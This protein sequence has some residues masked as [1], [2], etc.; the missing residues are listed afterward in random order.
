MRRLI[1]LSGAFVA[2]VLC[3]EI[4]AAALSTQF[5]LHRLIELGIPIPAT[6]RLAMTA[7]DIVGMLPLYGFTIGIAFAIALP[8]AGW[9]GRRAPAWRQTLYA[10]AG[11]IGIVTAILVLQAAFDIMPIAGARSLPGLIAQ[12]LAGAVAGGLFAKLLGAPPAP[13]T[14]QA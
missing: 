12:G 7:H 6:Q 11:G 2:S 3:A 4:L 9:I 1:R 14:P 8:V 5:V 10:A 13:T